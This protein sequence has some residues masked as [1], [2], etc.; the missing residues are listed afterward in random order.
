MKPDAL[1][2]IWSYE[3]DAWWKPG[4]FGYTSTLAEAGRS[5]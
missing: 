4:G 3:H 1:W 5:L 2:L